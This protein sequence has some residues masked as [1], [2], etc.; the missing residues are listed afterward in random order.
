MAGELLRRAVKDYVFLR[1]LSPKHELLKYFILDE[2]GFN[3]NP[4]DEA[5]DEFLEKFRGDVPKAEVAKS[6][7]IPF[8]VYEY[9]L[10]SNVFNN[11]INSLESAIQFVEMMN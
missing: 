8:K 6:R 5:I 3:I 10:T 7:R 2:N 1:K 11:Y 4:S 9:V